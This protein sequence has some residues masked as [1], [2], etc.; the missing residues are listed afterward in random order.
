M[1]HKNSV[2]NVNSGVVRFVARKAGR[3][4]VKLRIAITASVEGASQFQL[5]RDREFQDEV[6]IQVLDQLSLRYPRLPKNVVLMS[7]GS[8]FQL[9][10]NRDFAPGSRVTYSI[11]ETPLDGATA[12]T[13]DS[14]GL[15][16]AG[17]VAAT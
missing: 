10:T 14:N 17:Q 4:V 1:F 8:E 11:A 7:P 13:V 6:E 15:L 16:T 12:S 5:D 3:V 2:S 9:K